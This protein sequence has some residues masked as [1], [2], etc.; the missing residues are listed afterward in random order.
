[1]HIEFYDFNTRASY[2]ANCRGASG[3]LDIEDDVDISNPDLYIHGRD[4]DGDGDARFE[5][6]FFGWWIGCQYAIRLK[7]ET[8]EQVDLVCDSNKKFRNDIE[9]QNKVLAYFKRLVT[10]GFKYTPLIEN[11]GLY[12]VTDEFEDI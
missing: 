3:R 10:N 7:W 4:S 6:G 5:Y 1:M 11:D 2:Q 9:S 8:G 12:E